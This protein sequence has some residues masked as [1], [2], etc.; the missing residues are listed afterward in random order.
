MSQHGRGSGPRDDD[1]DGEDIEQE[2]VRK[3]PSASGSATDRSV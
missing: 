2:R 3:L 1:P